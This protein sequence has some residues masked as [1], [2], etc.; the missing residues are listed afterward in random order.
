[1]EK[2]GGNKMQVKTYGKRFK[3]NIPKIRKGFIGIGMTDTLN[4]Q[5]RKQGLL[6]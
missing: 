1:M 4:K 2:K 5:L 3:I 6:R